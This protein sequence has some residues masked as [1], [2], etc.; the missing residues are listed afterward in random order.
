MSEPSSRSMQKRIEHQTGQKLYTEADVADLRATVAR[1][2]H[3]LAESLPEMNC[4]TMDSAESAKMCADY[5]NA[6][7]QLSEQLATVTRERDDARAGLKW[8]L[9]Y[10]PN[11]FLMNQCIHC[12]ATYP[13]HNPDCP[14]R[15]AKL[16]LG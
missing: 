13:F 12:L 14:E 1:L 8:A 3:E 15:R 4:V 9:T 2:Q 6:N 16:A 10:T 7:A 5:G 11:P